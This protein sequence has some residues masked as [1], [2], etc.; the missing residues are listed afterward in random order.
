[1]VDRAADERAIRDVIA[2]WHAATRAGDTDTVLGLMA[3]D[4]LFLVAGAPPLGKAEFAANS[5]KMKGVQID[6]HGEVRE[7]HV[8][9]DWAF[10]RTDLDVK[11]TH[12]DGKTRSRKGQTLTIFT[13]TPE[14]AWVLYRD[15]NLLA[16]V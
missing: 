5:G 1:M 14:G 16:D 8:A 12:R 7:V 2:K 9:G 6:S 10:C 13:K 4:A 11:M 3:D 15:A